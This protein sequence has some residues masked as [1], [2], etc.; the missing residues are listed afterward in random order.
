MA[1][2]PFISDEDLKQVVQEV[3]DTGVKARNRANQNFE[4]NVI[5]PFA[6]LWEMASFGINKEQ[7]RE[8]EIC[9]QM[10]KSLANSI[11]LFHQRLL[12]KMHGWEDIKQKGAIDLVNH[13][14]KIIAEIK[15]KHNTVKAS[16]NIGMYKKLQKRVMDKGQE[17]KGYTAYL[18]QVIPKHP[19]R[20]DRPLAVPDNTTGHPSA[21]NELIRE[22]DGYSFYALATGVDDALEKVFEV[23]PYVIAECCPNQFNPDSAKKYAQQYFDAAYKE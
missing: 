11:G 10:Q 23:L 13:E 2:L 18:V 21:E 14:R 3:L 6:I 4:R 5:D 20:Y 15:N 16:D 17:Y 12:G 7:W 1:Y 19:Q 22:I 9:R 8:N